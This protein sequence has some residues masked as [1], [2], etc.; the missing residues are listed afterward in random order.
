LVVVPAGAFYALWRI[1]GGWQLPIAYG[2]VAAFIALAAFTFISGGGRGFA[3]EPPGDPVR[4]RVPLWM[5]AAVFLVVFV[6]VNAGWLR[7]QADLTATW[8]VIGVAY[9]ALAIPMVIA[10]II[11]IGEFLSRHE[12]LRSSPP[13]A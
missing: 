5:T 13:R 8:I 11:R 12:T 4:L 10:A 2:L 1:T 9:A 6:A 7:P 3:D